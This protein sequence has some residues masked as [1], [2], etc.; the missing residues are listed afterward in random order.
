MQLLITKTHCTYKVSFILCCPVTGMYST[1]WFGLRRVFFYG[2][3]LLFTMELF[4][5][6][7]ITETSAP[8]SSLN[9]FGLPLVV[10][11]GSDLSSCS[12]PL[13]K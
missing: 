4:W 10:V 12:A 8:V 5:A 9:L 2:C 13:N 7:D 1:F 3:G 11:H 6:A